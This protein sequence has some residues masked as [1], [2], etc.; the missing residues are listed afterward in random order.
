MAQTVSSMKRCE[1]T[2]KTH[3]WYPLRWAGSY[4]VLECSI[5]GCRA[6]R[7][8]IKKVRAVGIRYVTRGK[9]H[10]HEWRPWGYYEDCETL[11][12][13]F[14]NMYCTRSCTKDGCKAHQVAWELKPVGR[15][16]VEDT[17]T[18]GK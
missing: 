18:G 16:K 13:R 11:K 10:V 7:L 15:F 4:Y 5:M 17:K 3:Y 2:G 1:V 12:G 9:T 8:M 14:L 6:P